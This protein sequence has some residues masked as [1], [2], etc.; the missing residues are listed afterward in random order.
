MSFNNS[1]RCYTSIAQKRAL[2][3]KNLNKTSPTK[4]SGRF[5]NPWPTFKMAS[6]PDLIAWK[7]KYVPDDEKEHNKNLQKM[8]EASRSELNQKLKTH[9]EYI[10]SSFDASKIQSPVESGKVRVTWLGHASSMIQFSNGLNV[11]TDPVFSKR[12]SPSQLMGPARNTQVQ[13]EIAFIQFY[14]DVRFSVF[15]FLKL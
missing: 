14:L 7:R 10:D 9:Q 2:F 15:V 1:S 8:I 11:L 12:A 3:D 5:G 6:F 13:K 4:Q